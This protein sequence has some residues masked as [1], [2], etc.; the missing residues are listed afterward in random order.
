MLLEKLVLAISERLETDR[1]TSLPSVFI[2]SNCEELAQ[3]GCSQKHLHCK[4]GRKSALLKQ[5]PLERPP[6]SPTLGS[7][8]LPVMR[9][10]AT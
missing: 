9:E 3:P 6:S 4:A 5:A 2:P 1:D 8:D 7:L 10:A